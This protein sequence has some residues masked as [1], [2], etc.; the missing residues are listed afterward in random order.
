MKKKNLFLGGLLIATTMLFTSCIDNGGGG[1]T[2]TTVQKFFDVEG[3]TLVNKTKPYST[4]EMDITVDMN[5]IVIP[6]G[7]SIVD[8][9]SPITPKRIYVG[10]EDAK[11]YYEVLPESSNGAY[12]C[13]LIINQDIDLEDGDSFVIWVAITNAAG[14]ISETWEREVSLHAV[15]TG[16]LQVSLSFTNAK[17]VDLHL[18]EPNGEHIYYGN[19]TS[20]NGGHLDLD[21][22]AGCSIDNINNENITYG[23]DEYGNE[24][25]VEPGTYK[26]YVDM[27]SNCDPDVATG[28]SVTATYNGRLITAATG[29]NP[30]RG[31]FP[32]GEP[33]NHANLDNLTPVMTFTIG[34]KGQVKSV[35]FPKAPHSEMD[36]EKMAMEE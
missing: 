31:T 4:A 21:S 32:V 19:R 16:Q 14:D 23:T 2:S 9:Q 34:H 33:S 20:N 22:N 10:V 8:V 28:Y 11:G 27:Y 12:S 35:S 29:S 36:L 7:T 1:S 26:V 15:G 3:G 6:G 5:S 30:A 25:Y 18:I 13:V 17:D 24:A